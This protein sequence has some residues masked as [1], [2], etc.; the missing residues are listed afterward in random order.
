MTKNL[1][2]AKLFPYIL[3]APINIQRKFYNF[4]GEE[5]LNKFYNEYGNSSFMGFLFYDNKVFCYNI[6]I[7]SSV[8]ET[9]R[10]LDITKLFNS[11]LKEYNIF[12]LCY[13]FHRALFKYYRENCLTEKVLPYVRYQNDKN[14]KPKFIYA[15]QKHRGRHRLFTE[16]RRGQNQREWDRIILRALAKDSAC[17]ELRQY[18]N[19]RPCLFRTVYQALPKVNTV[20]YE[21]KP[22]KNIRQQIEQRKRHHKRNIFQRRR[23]RRSN[24][25]FKIN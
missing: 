10:Y 12:H 4:H 1:H 17:L 25:N 20:S 13:L 8:D 2:T 5:S 16:N 15:I 24:T 9:S 21:S 6:E 7:Y 3:D 23:F 22:S 18:L 11:F 19:Q 14:L